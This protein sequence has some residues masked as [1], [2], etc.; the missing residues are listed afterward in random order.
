M[1][2]KIEDTAQ[3]TLPKNELDLNTLVTK[4]IIYLKT[5]LWENRIQTLI[6]KLKYESHFMSYSFLG[7]KEILY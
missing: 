5:V 4:A 7:V 6:Y 2:P 3:Y 1:K